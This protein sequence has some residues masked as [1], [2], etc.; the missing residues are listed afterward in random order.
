[1]GHGALND[2]SDAPD[3][4]PC[5]AVRFTAG[6]PRNLQQPQLRQQQI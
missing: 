4:F 6:A 5:S 3:G 2:R 1:M